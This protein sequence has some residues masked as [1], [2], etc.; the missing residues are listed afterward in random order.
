M[1]DEAKELDYYVAAKKLP[2]VGSDVHDKYFKMCP[3]KFRKRALKIYTALMEGGAAL[4]DISAA[5]DNDDILGLV[6]AT[7]GPDHRHTEWLNTRVNKSSK[8]KKVRYLYSFY[9]TP[10]ICVVCNDS[11]TLVKYYRTCPYGYCSDEHYQELH[12]GCEQCKLH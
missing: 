9:S 11:T 10:K 3:K 12:P 8:S 1:T 2:P 6:I 4:D 7:L 5:N